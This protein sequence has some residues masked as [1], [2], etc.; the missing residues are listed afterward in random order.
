MGL[1]AIAMDTAGNLEHLEFVGDCA[2]FRPVGKVTLPEAIR[3][4]TRAITLAGQ[5]GG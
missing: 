3:P 1:V 2:F 5:R 4:V